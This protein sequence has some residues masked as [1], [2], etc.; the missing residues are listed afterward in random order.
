M[1]KLLGSGNFGKAYL[2]KHESEN[3][4]YVVKKLDMRCM[5]EQEQIQCKKEA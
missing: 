4:E 1:I 2:V 5:S 3:K